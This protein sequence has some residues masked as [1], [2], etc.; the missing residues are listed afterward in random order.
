MRTQID[1]LKAELMQL[2][3]VMRQ[4]DLNNVPYDKTYKELDNKAMEITST[5]NNIL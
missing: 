2:E 5:I 3:W 1:D 4:Y